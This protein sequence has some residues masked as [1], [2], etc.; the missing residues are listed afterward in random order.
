MTAARN[1]KRAHLPNA[2]ELSESS[3][4]CTEADCEANEELLEELEDLELLAKCSCTQMG[5]YALDEAAVR[6]RLENSPSPLQHEID[7]EIIRLDVLLSA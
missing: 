2:I 6:L 7:E 4:K 5:T 3:L 1:I